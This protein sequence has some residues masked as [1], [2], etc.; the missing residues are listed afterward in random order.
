MGNLQEIEE[1]LAYFQK[2]DLANLTAWDLFHILDKIGLAFDAFKLA[3][4]MNRLFIGCDFRKVHC[5]PALRAL[6]M[7]QSMHL[8]A[9]SECSQLRRHLRPPGSQAA[10][11]LLVHTQPGIGLHG[12]LDNLIPSSESVQN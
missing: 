12:L 7:W 8:Y 5:G 6:W 4:I 10:L 9:P 3:S 2:L 1:A 11:A